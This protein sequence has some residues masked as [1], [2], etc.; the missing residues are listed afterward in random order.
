MTNRQRLRLF[1]LTSAL[2]G[3][4]ALSAAAGELPLP[5]VGTTPEPAATAPGKAENAT[6]AKPAATQSQTDKAKPVAPTL[7]AEGADKAKP[8]VAK[9]AVASVKAEKADKLRPAA[10]ARADRARPTP[11]R[12]A[13]AARPYRVAAAPPVLPLPSPIEVASSEPVPA[14][15]CRYCGLPIVLGIAY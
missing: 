4:F 14:P 6:P 15:A 12:L 13:H 8:A 7:R 1:L 3:G 9:P 2:A 5:P 11:A 10:T